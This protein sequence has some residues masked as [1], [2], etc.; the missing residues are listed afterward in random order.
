MGKLIIKSNKKK[1]IKIKQNQLLILDALLNDGGRIKKFIDK[2]N[3]LRFTEHSGHF[4]FNGSSIDRIIV[5]AQTSREDSDDI[6]I[7]LPNNLYDTYEY[8]YFFHTHPPTPF[9]GS[10]AV[11]GILYEFPSVADIFHFIDHYNNGKT[12]GSVV[13]A[14][15][16]IYIIYPKRFSIK[17]IEYDTNIEN[18]IFQE[19]NN[20]SLQIQELAI[21]KYSDSFS[22]DFFYET[23]AQDTTFIRLFNK[24]INKLLNNQIKIIVKHRSKDLLTNK[25]IIK[26]LYLPI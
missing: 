2:S 11:H 18:E 15:E 8:E 25:W 17:K 1:Y 5:S 12:I 6:D 22:E 14:P 10:R 21:K 7:L 16:G 26:Q 3:I 4:G 24:K 13:I 19:L 20:S 9:I 23:I